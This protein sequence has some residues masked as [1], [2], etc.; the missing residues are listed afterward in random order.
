MWGE[1]TDANSSLGITSAPVYV[2]AH[3][4][5]PSPV[6]FLV[7]FP[8]SSSSF[9]VSSSNVIMPRTKLPAVAS[10]RLISAAGTQS[11]V[12][13][14]SLPATSTVD[15]EPTPPLELVR[16]AKRR[17]KKAERDERHD[18]TLALREVKQ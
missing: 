9:R 7:F 16:Y 11:G 6:L 3:I 12:A 13:S 5:A 2:F 15:S 14:S 8:S 1:Q 4:L 17:S 18:I 10:R